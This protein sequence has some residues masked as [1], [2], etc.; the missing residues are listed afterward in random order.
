[1]GRLK[2]P[3]LFTM[4]HDY[5]K[6][7]LPD[8][9]NSSPHTITAC[10]TALDQLIDFICVDKNKQLLEISI[11]DI[12]TE[13]VTNFLS[14]LENKKKCRVATR[15]QKLACIRSFLRYA[16]NR[17]KTFVVNYQEISAIPLK[18]KPT[19]QG[20]EYLTEK[21][22]EE[23]LKQPDTSKKSG[24]RN[25]F[26]MILLYDTGA[27][28]SELL[29]IRICDIKNDSTPTVQLLGKGSV[30]RTVPLMKETIQHYEN[31]LRV[32]HCGESS[33]S[34]RHL[35]YTKTHGEIHPMSDDNVRRFLNDY[36][37]QAHKT[38]LEVPEKI[39]PHLFRHSRAMHLYQHGMDLTLVSQWLGHSSLE[40]SLIYAHADTEMKRKA[41]EAANG[42]KD[43]SECSSKYTLDDDE[44]IKRLYGLR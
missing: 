30:F 17:D 42:K 13:N 10:R 31:Y 33:T 8:Q 4:I 22:I 3:E 21:A 6:I 34:K 36:A 20:I 14:W 5:L 43:S 19:M 11:D 29:N 15:N 2:K 1:M 44:L 26:M 28:I 40:V 23:L 16:V 12:N 7:Y 27:R 18:K 38:C 39:H 37:K 41:I 25:Q 9:K 35:F 32:Y 24:I